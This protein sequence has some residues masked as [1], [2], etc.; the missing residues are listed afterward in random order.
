MVRSWATP[1]LTGRLLARTHIL[2]YCQVSSKSTPPAG[3]LLGGKTGLCGGGV[4]A[5]VGVQAGRDKWA[6]PLEAR[7]DEG[8]PW[9]PSPDPRSSATS[10]VIRV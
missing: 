3:F 7:V 2:L 1:S 9:A 10:L 6:V 4:E 5:G 8:L